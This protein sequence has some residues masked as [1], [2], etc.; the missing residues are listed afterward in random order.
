[1]TDYNN[2]DKIIKAKYESIDPVFDAESMWADLAP[3]VERKRRKGFFFWIFAS[4]IL[5]LVTALGFGLFYSNVNNNYSVETIGQNVTAVAD[6][7]DLLEAD[8]SQNIAF[9][10][11][12]ISYNEFE[13]KTELETQSIEQSEIND[14]QKVDNVTVDASST[15][16]S[17]R[18]ESVTEDSQLE[19]VLESNESATLVN[20]IDEYSVLGQFKTRETWAAISLLPMH[21]SL[22]IYKPMELVE[23]N[24]NGMVDNIEI[25]PLSINRWR[26]AA[27]AGYYMHSRSFDNV[28]AELSDNFKSRSTEEKAKDGYDLGV[29]LEYFITDHLV[30]IGGARFSQSFVQR[31]ADYAYTEEVVLKDHIVTIVNTDQG[32]VEYKEDIIYDG[33]FVHRADNYIT[34]TRLGLITGLQYRVGV[35][36]W[37]SHVDIGLELPLWSSQHGVIT[38]DHRPYNLS[39][40]TETIAAS[41]LQI[42]G[43]I[44]VEYSVSANTALQ[45]TIGG[46][47]PLQNEHH[48]SYDIEKKSTLLGLNIGVHFRL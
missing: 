38:N 2:T 19:T 22:I 1:M 43:G 3:K 13:S 46:Y 11:N 31:S 21:N 33:V 30:V 29:K 8:P 15:M 17:F 5:L 41:S 39:E 23:A 27:N 25:V 35:D 44:G 16:F 32:P 42:F 9:E 24:E 47:M 34:D 20:S 10:S 40:D 48:K 37:V 12:E 6:S 14:K 18:S 45:A 4:V 26:L 28:G 7:N 36:R